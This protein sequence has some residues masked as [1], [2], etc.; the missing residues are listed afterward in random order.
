MRSPSALKPATA[1]AIAIWLFILCAMVFVMVVLGGVTRLT[2]SGLSM[3]EWKP[4]TGWL[5][6]MAEADWQALFAKYRETPEYRKVNAGMTLAGF[7]SIFWL[8]FFHRLWGRLI[9][10]VFLA[11]FVY[12]ALRRQVAGWLWPHLIAMLALGAAQGA[13]GWYMVMSGLVD[14]PDVSQYRLAAHLVLAVVIY[15]YMFWVAIGLIDSRRGAGSWNARSQRAG[16]GVLLVVVLTMISG[17]LVAGTDAGQVHNTF[18][19]M[20]EG[21]LPADL[22]DPALQPAILNFFEHRPAV[23]FDHRA[24]AFVSVLAVA[25]L[26]AFAYRRRL[27][28]GV[29]QAC[30]V[31]LAAVLAQAALG[32]ATLLAFV[33]VWLGALHQAGAMVLFTV[34][35]WT[36]HEIRAARASVFS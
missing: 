6:P 35:L 34:G 24:L 33:P 20:G 26:A 15:G 30:L 2:H 9:G 19:L 23:Q 27:S 14:R 28:R 17:A 22:I 32:V 5:P 10:V 31:L 11:P 13:L 36:L 1:R 4:V 12:F 3:V 16:Q 18:P 25:L 8:E 21:L 7:K 29:R